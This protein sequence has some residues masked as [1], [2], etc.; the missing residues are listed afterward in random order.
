MKI[1]YVSLILCLMPGLFADQKIEAQLTAIQGAVSDLVGYM[2]DQSKQLTQLNERVKK[3]IQH[4]LEEGGQPLG[5]SRVMIRQPQ[6]LIT[7]ATALQ[8]YQDMVGKI[9]QKDYQD[10][11]VKGKAL[12]Q[13]FP[14]AKEVPLTWY[15]LGEVALIYDDKDA[16][17]DYFEK[18]I[19]A[20]P[21]HEKEADIYLKLMTVYADQN[22]FDQAERYYQLLVASHETSTAM[23]LARLQRARYQKS[24]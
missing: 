8:L 14:D 24:S 3:T 15:W 16:A 21:R 6:Y 17:K 23:Y 11:V 9:E 5:G 20:F 2:D 18:L 7:Q 1:A 10:A 22:N 12:L 4:K 13:S 19:K